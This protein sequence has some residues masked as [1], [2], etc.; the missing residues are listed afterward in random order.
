MSEDR[1]VRLGIG[2]GLFMILMII[3][4]DS[5]HTEVQRIANTLEKEVNCSVDKAT[6]LRA[7]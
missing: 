6:H 4:L 3:G 1:N 7:R 5:I 2:A